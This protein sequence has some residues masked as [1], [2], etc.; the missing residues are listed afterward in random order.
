MSPIERLDY[1]LLWL[2]REVK[3]TANVTR[4]DVR[5]FLEL[6]SKYNIVPEIKVYRLED[7]NQAL[8]DLKHNKFFGQA[9]LKIK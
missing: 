1:R 8:H 2:E 4:R 6:A 3:T 7:A 5:E 9:V